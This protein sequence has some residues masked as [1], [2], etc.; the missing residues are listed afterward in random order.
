MID[1]IVNKYINEFNI[2]GLKGKA[3]QMTC[4]HEFSLKDLKYTGVTSPKKPTTNDI[5]DWEK[6]LDDLWDGDWRDHIV[7]WKCKKCGK[8]FEGTCGLDIS[9]KY[10]KIVK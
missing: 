3:K 7:K 5:K 4:S 1:D 6:Y 2:F 9:P 8:E 10:G